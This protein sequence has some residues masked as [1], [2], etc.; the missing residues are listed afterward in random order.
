MKRTV[1]HNLYI[2]DT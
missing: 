2:L 1:H